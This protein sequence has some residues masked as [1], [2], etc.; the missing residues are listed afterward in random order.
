[1]F[2]VACFRIFAKVRSELMQFVT[3]YFYF[4]S[5][6]CWNRFSFYFIVSARRFYISVGP[7]DTEDLLG[8]SESLEFISCVIFCLY[9]SIF[10][11]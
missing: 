9:C 5:F 1:V 8:K 4:C 7:R 2:I 6:S 11:L 10:V 3:R